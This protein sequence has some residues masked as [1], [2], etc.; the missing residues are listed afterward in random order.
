ML[1][2]LWWILTGHRC[3][4]QSMS[5]RAA[6]MRDAGF[7]KRARL[8]ILFLTNFDL[9]RDALRLRLQSV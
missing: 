6:R 3:T 5:K 1:S 7:A 8:L 9:F 2:S 4:G